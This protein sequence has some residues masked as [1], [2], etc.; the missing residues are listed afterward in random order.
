MKHTCPFCDTHTLYHLNDGRLE[1]VTCKRRFSP[2]KQQ[3]NR[4]IIDAFLKGLTAK[5]TSLVYKISFPTVFEKYSLFRQLITLYLEAIYRQK[6]ETFSEYEEYLFLPRSK[7][8][9]P[10][11]LLEGIGIMAMNKKE[12]VYT[13]LMPDHFNRYQYQYLQD[14]IEHVANKELASYLHWNK[15]SKLETFDTPLTKFWYFL[16]TF[17]G[18]FHGVRRE[19]FSDY[20]K[21]AEFRFNY[22][23]DEQEKILIK[24]WKEYEANPKKGQLHLYNITK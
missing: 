19:Y 16:E 7:R 23:H 8:G 11:F 2:K 14:G 4:Q 3:K 15:I 13:L 21:E 9:D 22:T 5:E 1:C 6:D 18:K 20:L 17:M 10:K 24:L 12:Y